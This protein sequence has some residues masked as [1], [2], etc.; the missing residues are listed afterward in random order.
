MNEQHQPQTALDKLE[1]AIAAQET[2]RGILDD[3]QI[4]TVLNALYEKRDALLS[5]GGIAPEPDVQ[6]TLT[7]SGAAAVGTGVAVAGAGGTAVSGNVHGP[8]ITGDHRRGLRVSSPFV[9]HLK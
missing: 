4:E 6:A 8:I 9:H 3:A 1:Q 7:G 5:P 2:L